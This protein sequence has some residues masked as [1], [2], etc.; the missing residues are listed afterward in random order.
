VNKK[1][2]NILSKN[3]RISIYSCRPMH[4]PT[5]TKR[6]AIAHSLLLSKPCLCIFVYRYI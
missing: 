1:E 2:L 6:V 3:W 4:R 5:R